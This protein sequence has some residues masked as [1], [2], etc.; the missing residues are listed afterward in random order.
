[1]RHYQ[2]FISASALA[3]SSIAPSAASAEDGE[4]AYDSPQDTIVV[5]G[6][7][8]ERS[9][10]ETTTSV[11]VTTTERIEQEN[12]Q[13][14]QEIYQRTAN[15]SETY[16]ASGFSIRGI[17]QRGVSGGGDGSTATVFVDGA[18]VPQEVLSNGPTDLWDVAQVEIFRG[19]QSTIQGLNAL[20][21]AV[22][23]RTQDP[24][25]YWSLRGS[26]EVSSFDT[27]RFA[28]AG[29]GPIVPGELAFRISGEKRDSDGYIHNVTRD[30]PEA[31]TDTTSIRGKLLWTPSALPEF[32]ARLTYHHF[33]TEGGYVFVYTDRSVG[34]Y[35]ENPTNSSDFPNSSVVDHDQVTLDLRYDLGGDFSLNALG[36]YSDTGYVRKYDG[37]FSPESLAYSDISGAEEI[38]TQELRLNYDGERLSGLVGLFYNH[39]DRTRQSHQVT[40][41]QTPGSTI[42]NLLAGSLGQETAEQ[43]AA[44][45]VDALPYI[46]VDYTSDFPSKVETMAVFADAR[47]ALTD[48]LSL[49]GGFRYDRERNRIGGEAIATFVGTLPDPAAYGPLAPAFAG[50]NAAV[51]GL[52]TDA[53]GSA[54]AGTRTFNAFLPK[55]GME[56]AW[57][58]DLSTAFVVQRGY[59]SGG[60]SFNTARSQL[61]AYDPEYTW[62]YELSLR[63]AW[64]D[65]RLTVNANAFYIDWTEQ[66]TNA[67]FG[68]GTY[69]AHTVNAG[70]SHVYGFEVETAYDV[71]DTFDIY[72]SVGHTRT[73]FD[74]FITDVGSITDLSGLEFPYA[75]KW[76]L[77]G[78]ANLR[79]GG[80]FNANLNASYRS[81]VFTDVSHPQADGLVGARTLVNARIG[82]EADYWSLSLYAKNL[83]DEQYDQYVNSVTNYAI[84]G[85]PRQVGVI[86]EAGF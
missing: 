55:A 80:G 11:A 45:Y 25:F 36:T 30:E 83:L 24:T 17:D 21:G 46:P 38:F 14:I 51:L 8:T 10:Q 79:F 66:Q 18:P 27:T 26:A 85:T 44:L 33:E 40:L 72:A 82:Y 75:P 3:L 67:N 16:G 62:N 28:I 19:P 9:L 74:E 12:V 23:I 60:S 39:R 69:D 58:P 61:F 70:K 31:S 43:V 59:R 41:V 63:S 47:F 64:L 81:A 13:T 29:G 56:M 7:K 65:N 20:A 48:R 15:L 5:T 54:P 6:E 42:A 77:A 2:L 22:H 53:N 32:E 37:D 73:Q 76:T 86:L 57:T 52:V 34:D 49:L 50:V 84:I 68:N 78:G 35:F 4:D 1:M 71:S